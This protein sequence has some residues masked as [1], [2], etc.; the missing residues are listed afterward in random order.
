M[1]V[2]ESVNLPV[3][4]PGVDGAS[5][6]FRGLGASIGGAGAA[7][8]GLI[9]TLAGGLI[10]RKAATVIGGFELQMAKVRGVSGA[11]DEQFKKLS[12][13]A[14]LL[15]ATT[16]F[17]ARQAGE[18]LEELSKAGFTAEQSI[19][20]IAAT[21]RLAQAGSLGLGRASEITAAAINSFNLEA[22][23]AAQ[24]A[25]VLVRASQR[26]AVTV[27]SLGQAMTFLGATAN[28]FGISLQEAVASVG[29]LASLGIPASRAGRAL[30]TSYS[31][32]AKETAKVDRAA[33]RYGL[34]AADLNP[35]QKGFIVSLDNIARSFSS[36]GEAAKVF[37]AINAR[38]IQGLVSAHPRIR[39]LVDQLKNARGASKDFADIIGMTLFGAY[40]SLISATEESIIQLGDKGLR[41]VLTDL[42]LT[43]AGTLN[44]L[45][46]T[47]QAFLKNNKVSKD[48]VENMRFLA[49]A[50]KGVGIIAEGTLTVFRILITSAGGLGKAIFELG[51]T[52]GSALKRDFEAAGE[53]AKRLR[54]EIAEIPGRIDKILASS[55]TFADVDKVFGRTVKTAEDL[56]AELGKVAKEGENAG[57]ELDRLGGKLNKAAEGRVA[58]IDAQQVRDAE[59]LNKE[60]ESLEYNANKLEEAF[61][62][63]TQNEFFSDTSQNA[64][65]AR[66]DL[67]KLFNTTQD[68][69][70]ASRELYELLKSG[71]ATEEQLAA[72][73]QKRALLSAEVSNLTTKYSDSQARLNMEIRETSQ[74]MKESERL[75]KKATD[76]IKEQE[77][78]ADKLI[79]TFKDIASA[80]SDT[81]D[82]INE[83]I[84]AYQGLKNAQDD[85]RRAES[86]IQGSQ[87]AL[88]LNRDLQAEY[89][90][91][92]FSRIDPDVIRLREKEQELL[93]DI[94]NAT[95]DRDVA[96]E[97]SRIEGNKLFI[98]GVEKFF[99]GVV[100]LVELF[101]SFKSASASSAGS[102]A[103][104]GGGRLVTFDNGARAIVPNFHS[105]G[106]V[107]GAAGQE[108]PILAQAGEAILTQNQLR[109]LNRPISVNVIDQR[110][111]Q[112]AAPQI[113]NDENG[114][115]DI[116]LRDYFSNVVE[117]GSLDRPMKSRYGLQSR[118]F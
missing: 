34:T 114:N 76:S 108:V 54:N 110:T 106:I 61:T 32:L 89:A 59:L 28:S 36:S 29:G 109:R 44:I 12:E 56:K 7:L 77:K 9:A 81:A 10:F 49:R 93:T 104:A 69:I 43:L 72:A 90:E 75:N 118:G 66:N 47:E 8:K 71:T 73:Q 33:K 48:V 38:A 18:G 40:K 117:S 96:E 65:D 102:A 105:G 84:E 23:Q 52:V 15:G 70:K 99:K 25:D 62:K 45:N 22:S 2:N 100:S 31:E 97:N 35:I 50:F 19:D 85:V 88:Q 51:K 46:N 98:T 80:I 13:T 115:V 5:R 116:I 92:G 3:R 78:E 30:S 63:S 6:K 39:A 17:S 101:A 74:A 87:D 107:S 95:I 86:D 26:S 68:Y 67:N 11:T 58:V 41:K 91:R 27:D 21:L 103:N 113:S 20:A 60:I 42:S 53:S 79:D 55:I 4:A 16:I 83:L 14:R 82:N 112:T 37:G 24:V 57:K 111:T 94:R 1:P 64:T